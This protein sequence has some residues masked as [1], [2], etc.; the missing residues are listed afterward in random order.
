MIINGNHEH[1]EGVEQGPKITQITE[2]WRDLRK[3]LLNSEA[4]APGL[5]ACQRAQTRTKNSVILMQN[6]LVSQSWLLWGELQPTHPFCPFEKCAVPLHFEAGRDSPLE[7]NDMSYHMLPAH[8]DS[9]VLK[10]TSGIKDFTWMYSFFLGGVRF[11]EVQ[12]AF[13]KIH[14]FTV[15]F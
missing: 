12:F 15:Q 8:H 7:S 14:T 4:E 3:W 1:G 6:Y 5:P 2:Q 9:V 13:S 11:T 10:Q